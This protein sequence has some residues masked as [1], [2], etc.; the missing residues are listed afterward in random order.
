MLCISIILGSVCSFSQTPSEG[1]QKAGSGLYTASQAEAGK[2][3]YSTYCAA[4]HGE[5][6]RAST[7]PPLAGQKFVDSWSPLKPGAASGAWNASLDDVLFILQSTMPLGD[8]KSL[9][10]DEHVAIFAYILQQNGYPAGNTP[11]RPDSPQLKTTGVYSTTLDAS[12]AASPA[13]AFIPG[14]AKSI[15]V[16]LGPTQAELNAGQQSSQDWLYHTHDY[17]GSSFVPLSQIDP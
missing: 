10:S 1:P 13:P 12:G 8:P 4:C 5:G 15:P 3:L 17:S 7:A 16:G 6:L 11:L 2:K 14:E 9:S